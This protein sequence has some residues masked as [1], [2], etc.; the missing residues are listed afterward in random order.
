MSS[1]T[2]NANALSSGRMPDG[3]LN[4]YKEM[5]KTIKGE[6][7]NKNIYFIEKLFQFTFAFKVKIMMLL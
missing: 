1:T 2:R 7:I 6:Y 3:N 5:R 4:S